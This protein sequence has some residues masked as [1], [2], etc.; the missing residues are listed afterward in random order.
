VA[1]IQAR[2]SSTRLPGKVLQEIG[3]K[4][5]LA[6]VLQRMLRATLVD[7]VTLATTDREVDDPVAREGR[8]TGVSVFRGNEEDVLDRYYRA[9]AEARADAVV[10]ITADCPLIDPE[11]VDRVA[12]AFLSERSDYASNVLARMYP[13]GLDTEIMTFGALARAWREA[14]APHERAHVTPYIY[15]H[16]HLFRIS[17]V[18]AEDDYSEHRWTVDT[19][20]DLE[21]VRII[22]A[23]C[24]NRDDISWREVLAFLRRKPELVRANRSVKQK[25]LEEG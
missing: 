12:A 9:A 14:R 8:K 21:W 3:G 23:G 10:R 25:A 22:Y 6:R 4:T 15:S 16:P 1:I 18:T 20:E 2:L 5:M 11:V 19:A 13:R 7:G 24:G 17:S